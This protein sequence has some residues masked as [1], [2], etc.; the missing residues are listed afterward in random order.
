LRTAESKFEH[1]GQQAGNLKRWFPFHFQHIPVAAILAVNVQ[2]PRSVVLM[3]VHLHTK[4]DLPR[5][6]IMTSTTCGEAASTKVETSKACELTELVRGSDRQLVEEMAP[7]V[8][9]EDLALDLRMVE[10][11]DAAGIAALISLYRL[12]EQSGH[13]FS[14]FNVAP[15]VHELLAL[16]GLDRVLL[17]HNANI[18]S[19][20]GSE[21]AQSA[22]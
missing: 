20:S 16:V 11:I 13:G 22:A 10:R 4:W 14:V 18:E 5:R 17:S 3:K 12:A 6:L 19:K 9:R 1:T 15:R 21:L 2:L 7:V 8:S